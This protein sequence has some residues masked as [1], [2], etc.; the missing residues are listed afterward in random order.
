[1]E[2]SHH[3]S[4]TNRPAATPWLY[5]LP[6]TFHAKQRGQ[7]SLGHCIPIHPSGQPQ[8]APQYDSPYRF[9]DITH[10]TPLTPGARS[11][12]LEKSSIIFFFCPW[13][14]ILYAHEKAGTSLNTLLLYVYSCTYRRYPV[15]GRRGPRMRLM[16]LATRRRFSSRR[17]TGSIFSRHSSRRLWYSSRR[18]WAFS[19]Y[20]YREV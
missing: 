4:K 5:S 1:M 12:S 15:V 6:H 8:I 19:R 2:V 14:L 7:I 16:P 17:T 13:V 9:L 11:H 3:D 20:S 18:A 10:R